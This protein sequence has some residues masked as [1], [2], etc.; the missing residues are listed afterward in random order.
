MSIFDKK[1][2]DNIDSINEESNNTFNKINEHVIEYALKMMKPNKS[3][4]IY[5][6]VSDMYTNGPKELVSHLTKLIR[7]FISLGKVPLV[8]LVCTLVPLVKD[9]LGDV[10]VIDN[11][12]A[13]AGN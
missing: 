3:D 4:A 6:S 1:T 2:S 12:R 13:I 10:T 5:N 8:T 7:L 9:N 11:S